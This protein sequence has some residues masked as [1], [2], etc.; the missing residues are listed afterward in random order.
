MASFTARFTVSSIRGR[1]YLCAAPQR[2]GVRHAQSL[3]RA[4]GTEGNVTCQ[5][6]PSGNLVWSW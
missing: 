5:A 3:G 4:F 2:D 1:R 6:G